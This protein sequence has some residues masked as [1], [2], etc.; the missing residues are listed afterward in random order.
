I[1]LL[2]DTPQVLPGALTRVAP[3]GSSIVNLNRG[4]SLKDTWILD[5][6]A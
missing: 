4:G 1:S 3:P 2:G 5:D 6:A